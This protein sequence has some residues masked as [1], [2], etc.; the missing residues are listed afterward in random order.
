MMAYVPDQPK[1]YGKLTVREFLQLV[2]ALYRMPKEAA[3]ERAAQLMAMFGLAERA[4][5]LLE[6]YSH[7]C[8]KVVLAAALIHQPRVI[9]LMNLQLVWTRPVHAAKDVLQEMA[10]G[11]AV[12]CLPTF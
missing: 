7:G 6:G 2:A 1:I 8:G 9:L 12:F 5:E 4:D 10:S 11:A 3:Q